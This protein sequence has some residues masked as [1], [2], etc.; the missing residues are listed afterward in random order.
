VEETV[1]SLFSGQANNRTLF[2]PETRDSRFIPE[3]PD[4]TASPE[5]LYKSTIAVFKLFNL[6]IK[7]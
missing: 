1:P 5:K 3:V 4:C 6:V 7:I 2:S